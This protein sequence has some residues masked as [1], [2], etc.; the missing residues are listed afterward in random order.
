MSSLM[1]FYLAVQILDA[2]IAVDKWQPL[3]IYKYLPSK[4]E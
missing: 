3:Q 4:K 1:F 2:I